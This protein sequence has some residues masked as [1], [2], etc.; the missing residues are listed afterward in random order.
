[1]IEITV[2]EKLELLRFL[3]RKDRRKAFELGYYSFEDL[4]C[5]NMEWTHEEFIEWSANGRVPNA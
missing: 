2:E 3:W 1:M 5:K 4:V